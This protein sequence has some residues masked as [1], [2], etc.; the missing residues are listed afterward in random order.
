MQAEGRSYSKTM[1]SKLTS[2]FESKAKR[3]EPGPGHYNIDAPK[4]STKGGKFGGRY[5]SKDNI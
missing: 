4:N 3:L 1:A 2:Q 5:G